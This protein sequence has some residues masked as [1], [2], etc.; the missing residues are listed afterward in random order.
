MLTRCPNCETTF[1]VTPEQLKARHG[2]VRCGECQEV[3]DALETLIEAAP[4]VAAPAIVEPPQPAPEP[5][6]GAPALNE[7]AAPAEEAGSIVEAEAE[8][9]AGTE[10][11]T[12]ASVPEP[13]P[14]SEP[15][16]ETEPERPAASAGSEQVAEPTPAEE[17]LQSPEALR[18]RRR[19]PWALG[20]LAAVFLLALQT[21]MHFRTE[22][23]VLHPDTKPLLTTACEAFGCTL[24]LPRKAELMSIETSD[25]H[26]E[27]EGRLTLTAMLKN[28]APF[29]Q[30]HPHLELTLTDTA[31]KALVRR[32]LPPAEYLPATERSPGFPAG[33]ELPVE[34]AIDA[35]GVPAAGYRLYLFY[36]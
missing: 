34:L 4:T 15:E 36:P 10:P 6:P 19:W 5:E 23:A 21:V 3:F 8:I 28:R 16:P 9:E 30:E 32:V 12:M 33:K 1:R 26:P 24:L 14:A 25:L 20:S 13:Q 22:I 31:D 11:P 29:A 18:P 35:P 7:E 2:K 27:A 17:W